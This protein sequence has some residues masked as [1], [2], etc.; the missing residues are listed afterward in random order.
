MPIVVTPIDVSDGGTDEFIDFH[1]IE[2]GDFDAVDC[3]AEL[4]NIAN[5]E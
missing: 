3:A 5:A 1:V 4:W 2:A